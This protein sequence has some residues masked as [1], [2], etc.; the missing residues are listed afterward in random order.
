MPRKNLSQLFCLR[1]FYYKRHFQWAFD[2]NLSVAPVFIKQIFRA[3]EVAPLSPRP[4]LGFAGG[5]V[6]VAFFQPQA[7]ALVM[8]MKQWG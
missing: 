6:V 3:V 4:P 7:M 5:G 2:D 8:A 1:G